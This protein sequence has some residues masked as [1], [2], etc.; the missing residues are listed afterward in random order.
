MQSRDLGPKVTSAWDLAALGI[1]GCCDLQFRLELDIRGP[2]PSSV[3]MAQWAP[4]FGPWATERAISEAVPRS[5]WPHVERFDAIHLS[6]HRR[7]RR[8]RNATEGSRPWRGWLA[9]FLGAGGYAARTARRPP[10]P[11]PR[12]R[13]GRASTEE[14]NASGDSDEQ[15]EPR[16]DAAESKDDSDASSDSSDD[17]GDESKAEAP[18]KEDATKTADK[19]DEKSTS[20][21]DDD[22]TAEGDEKSEKPDKEEKAGESEE[23]SGSS[24]DSAGEEPK[25]EAEKSEAVKEEMPMKEEEEEED[26]ESEDEKPK[27]ESAKEEKPEA[28]E[29]DSDS[30]DAGNEPEEKEKDSEEKTSEPE[31]EDT[32]KSESGKEEEEKAAEAEESEKQEGKPKEE[33]KPKESEQKVEEEKKSES[34]KVEHKAEEDEKSESEQAEKSN[35]NPEE[36]VEKP[37]ESAPPKEESTKSQTENGEK[38][39]KEEPPKAKDSEESKETKEEKKDSKKPEGAEELK[40]EAEAKNDKKDKEPKDEKGKDDGKEEAKDKTEE[41]PKKAEESQKQAKLSG[42]EEAVSMMGEMLVALK[43]EEASEDEDKDAVPKERKQQAVDMME[44]VLVAFKPDEKR[45]EK[46]EEE[47]VTKEM[48]QQAKEY[49]DWNRAW[50]PIAPL[51]YLHADKPNPVKLLGKRMVVWCSDVAENIWHAALD[52]CPHRMAPL[53]I[54]EVLDSGELRCR[55]HGWSFNGAGS[56]V[57]V[58]QARNEAEEAR[59]SGLAR[60]CLT[61]F[62]VQ[63]KQGLVWIFPFTGQDATTHAKKSAPCVTPEMDG[64][65][66][67]MTVAP[68]GYQVSVENTFDP[69]HAPFLHNGIVKYAA[70]R[71]RAITK[72]VLRDDVISGKRGFVLQHNGYD[73]S[74]EGIAATRQFV[75][76]CSNTTVYK[77]ADGRVETNQLYFVPCG[78]HETRYIVN[79]GAGERRRRLPTIME[80]VLHVLFFNKIFGYRFQEQ[81]LMAMCGQERAL[82]ESANYAWGEQYVLGTPA[83]KGVEVFRRWFYE[84]ANGGPYFPRSSRTLPA[85]DS[86]LFDRWQRH[87]KYCPRCRRVMRAFGTVQGAAGRISV[88]GLIASAIFFFLHRREATEAT[89]L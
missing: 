71:A 56:C 79:L 87:S 7:P 4:G 2:C 83:D 76:P 55:Y 6:A 45:K 33:E 41:A 85:T 24:E 9:G 3:A 30:E 20:A 72:F 73:E 34:E 59:I 36:D 50:Y 11:A 23:S 57:C 17:E 14:T 51:D 80:D 67:I 21:S 86:M 26:G 19:N 81:D 49:F 64:A 68:V 60:S 69:S 1:S 32:D 75:P 61:T 48:K 15:Q 37:V 40:N 8:L 52:S 65:E 10:K 39:K 35:E 25:K 62:P 43:S 88:C 47:G 42:T 16:A 84:F 54:G 53:S 58:P 12:P 44:E 5:R 46:D 22:S 89:L 27:Q 31:K 78:P 18:A 13:V 77:Y 74:T 66:W 28:S 82:Q 29:K 38:D 70:E 63:V